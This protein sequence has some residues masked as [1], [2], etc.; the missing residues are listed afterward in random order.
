L[1]IIEYPVASPELNPQEQVWKQTRRAVTHNHT[2]AKLPDLVDRFEQYLLSNTFHSS[3]LERYG[4]Y[5]V[6]PFL[7]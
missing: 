1:T 5:L 4:F 6:C 2:I 3:F 7:N